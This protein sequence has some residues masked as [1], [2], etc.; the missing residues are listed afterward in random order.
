MSESERERDQA[1]A[2]YLLGE[3]DEVERAEFDRHLAGDPGLRGEVEGLRGVVSSLATLPEQAWTPAEPPPLSAPGEAARR[4]RA[5]RARPR[6]WRWTPARLAATAGLAALLLGAG[7]WIG[8]VVDDDPG[9]VGSLG[10]SSIALTPLRDGDAARGELTVAEDD[11]DRASLSVSG[12]T[13]N[14][15]DFYEVWLLGDRGL[16]SLGSF[17]VGADGSATAELALPVD[18]ARYGSFDV[19]LEP[20]DG[21]PSH[22][23]DSVLRGPAAS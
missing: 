20:D 22:S 2:A 19:S 3:L 14:R 21:D 11:G 1:I 5:P 6:A 7:I 9:G 15:N 16:V 10:G 4:A 17:R 13:P 23:S 12:L 8:T 18:P